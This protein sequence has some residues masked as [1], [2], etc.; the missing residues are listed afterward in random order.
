MLSRRNN[1][2][3]QLFL[4]GICILLIIDLGIEMTHYYNLGAIKTT[5]N[6]TLPPKDV[7]GAPAQISPFS[8]YAEITQRPLFSATRMPYIPDEKTKKQNKQSSTSP[9]DIMSEFYFLSGIVIA[10]GEKLALI[11]KQPNNKIYRLREGDKVD[12]WTVSTVE[13][14]RVVLRNGTKVRTLTL[15]VKPSPSLIGVRPTGV[16]H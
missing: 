13:S 12:G 2:Y 6:N 8:N 11:Q 15:T 16:A 14:M 1:Q 7:D 5:T 4:I 9:N 10:K 3:L